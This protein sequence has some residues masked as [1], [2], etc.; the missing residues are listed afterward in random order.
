MVPQG[1]RL[2]PADKHA[3]GAGGAGGGPADQA[4]PARGHV[5]G[6]QDLHDLGLPHGGLPHLLAALLHLDAA[7]HSDGEWP[8]RPAQAS[9]MTNRSFITNSSCKRPSSSISTF[10]GLDVSNSFF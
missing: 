7:G 6:G 1:A 5:Q 8:A 9:N 4:H 3:A 10:S 2:H